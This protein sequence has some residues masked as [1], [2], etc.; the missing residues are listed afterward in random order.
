MNN[1]LVRSSAFLALL[2]VVSLAIP[3]QA[4]TTQKIRVQDAL[5]LALEK[6][7]EFRTAMLQEELAAAQVTIEDGLY[8]FVLQV[9][10]GYTHTS[11]P[12][13]TAD[14]ALQFS[15]ADNLSLGTEL[16]KTLPI[17]T[18]A[19]LRLEGSRQDTEGT[20][21]GLDA[22]GMPNPTYGVSAKLSITQPL[23][24]GAGNT[25][26]LASLRQA[27]N[28]QTVA[29]KSAQLSASKLARDVQQAYWELWYSRQALEIDRRARDIAASQVQETQDRVQR[30]AAAPNDLL[31]FQTRLATL[32][33]TVATAETT[34]EQMASKLAATL[35]VIDSTWK[36]EPDLTQEPPVPSADPSLASVEPQAISQAPELLQAT[37]E[38]AL[39]E[40][41]VL[42]AGEDMRQRLDLTGWVEAQTLGDSK[43]PPALSHFGHESAL[44]GYVGLI[45]EWPFG[46]AR[47][48]SELAAARISVEIARKQ[49][50]A[51]QDQ[52][53]A[54]LAGALD[55]LAGTRRRLALAETTL[56]IAERSAAAERERL[57]AGSS[58]FTSVR[59][60]EEAVRE[61]SLRSV[62]ARVDL[63]TARLD[64]DHLTGNLLSSIASMLSAESPK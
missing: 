36:I 6:N 62:R 27:R 22:A 48:A 2:V 17:G 45:Y 26:G 3:S 29:Q 49:L 56:G 47:K 52:V 12:G 40:D 61:A 7:A 54:D 60:A 23:L 24:R 39:A 44:S 18:T 16:R 46:C 53:K 55:N 58:I 4:D 15:K 9:D 31:S 30:G 32:D 63:T 14:S 8:P 37:A 51:A 38:V 42:I 57:R 5:R 20:A 21:T 19:T 33:E 50:Q 11:T 59:D 13:L 43:A 25:V 35:G 1:R 64:L 41:K 34:Y 28:S 10:G